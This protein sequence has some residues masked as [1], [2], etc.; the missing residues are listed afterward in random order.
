MYIKGKGRTTIPIASPM[1]KTSVWSA[2]ESGDVRKKKARVMWKSEREVM[3]VAPEMTAIF[4]DLEVEPKED[5][6]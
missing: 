5:G 6:D 4:A 1:M 3:I 2:M